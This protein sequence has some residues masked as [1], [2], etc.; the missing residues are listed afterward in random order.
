MDMNDKEWISVED[1]LPDTYENVWV[2]GKLGVILGSC[3]RS[4]VD[5]YW[6]N[7][8]DES[9]YGVT[10]W[11]KIDVPEPPREEVYKEFVEALNN[12]TK[13]TPQDLVRMNEFMEWYR[14][15]QVG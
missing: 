7:S 11:M 2:Y 10:H 3:W 9:I 4:P 15:Q 5:I 14:G 13:L 6:S 1:R 12:Q 8:N